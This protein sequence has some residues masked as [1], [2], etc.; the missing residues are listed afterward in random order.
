MGP[1]KS[2]CGLPCFTCASFAPPCA[3]RC[4]LRSPRL[5]GS[6]SII[7]SFRAKTPYPLNERARFMDQMVFVGSLWTVEPHWL[8]ARKEWY[9]WTEE[10]TDAYGRKS[11]HIFVHDSSTIGSMRGWTNVWKGWRGPSSTFRLSS[12]YGTTETCV[13][14]VS[15]PRLER[16]HSFWERPRLTP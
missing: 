4:K 11:I 5:P 9:K 2:E 7:H 8:I 13:A 3:C 1:T 6:S 15:F 10:C 12:L 16:I 14:S